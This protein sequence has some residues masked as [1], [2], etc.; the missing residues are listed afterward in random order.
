MAGLLA[1]ISQW[2]S[3]RKEGLMKVIRHKLRLVVRADS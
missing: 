3:Q 1:A 2:A